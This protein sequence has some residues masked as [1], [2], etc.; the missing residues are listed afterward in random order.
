MAVER[1]NVLDEWLHKYTSDASLATA[2]TATD[3]NIQWNNI[4]TAQVGV[5]SK[6]SS[7]VYD[8]IFRLALKFSTSLA[9][10]TA[11]W[12]HMHF[13]VN[14][15]QTFVTPPPGLVLVGMSSAG[16]PSAAGAFD[17]FLFTALSGVVTLEGAQD[18]AGYN[19]VRF[20]LN[21][22]G[23]A[24]FATAGTKYIGI[25][26]EWDRAGS[27]SGGWED[28]KTDYGTLCLTDAAQPQADPVLFLTDDPTTAVCLGDAKAAAVMPD[29]LD[30]M[31]Q[32]SAGANN[33]AAIADSVAAIQVREYGEN[34]TITLRSLFCFDLTAYAGMT[35]V[36]AEIGYRATQAGGDNLADQMRLY[37][38]KKAIVEAEMTG[39]VYKSGSAW[40]DVQT[41][42]REA[43]PFSMVEP[44]LANGKI[45][46]QQVASDTYAQMLTDI[47][48]VLA[49]TDE[50][51]A[52]RWNVGLFNDINN[53]RY[54]AVANINHASHSYDSP[55]LVL[56]LTAAPSV[57]TKTLSMDARIVSQTTKVV[58]FDA[59]IK[60][61]G[62]F[63]SVGSN[64]NNIGLAP[65]RLISPFR[66]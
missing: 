62:G 6:N 29:T 13:R 7:D 61:A 53:N 15:A 54:Q 60:A 65:G 28:T 26:H 24:Y 21:A 22:A 3:S 31:F 59:S 58:A 39:Q 4:T 1:V 9:A 10:P 55:Y 23:L 11:G 66:I 56:G 63:G 8:Q 51:P 42:D 43:N 16:D 20:Q 34:D 32:V 17:E 57:L 5:W 48:L 35:A 36:Y 14:N 12:L 33:A 45:G 46:R 2:H 41:F 50:F 64:Q 19:L 49:G 25:I 47:N 52:N 30:K 27:D 40:T 44:F 38:I 37:T 18:G